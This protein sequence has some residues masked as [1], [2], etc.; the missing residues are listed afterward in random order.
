[1]MRLWWM[2]VLAACGKAGSQPVEPSGDAACSYPEGA[3]TPMEVGEVLAPYR[4][5]NAIHGDGRQAP[6][7][8]SKV[9]CTDNEDID[10][11]PFD[12]LLFVSLPAF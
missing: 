12:A 4:W 6:L 2:M 7:D 1:M 11:N 9:P 8:L 3:A 5:A 10:F